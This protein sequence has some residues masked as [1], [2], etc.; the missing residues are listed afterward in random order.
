M[1]Y[2][3]IKGNQRADVTRALGDFK[4]AVKKAGIMSDL[5]DREGFR[6]KADKQRIKRQRA[7]IQRRKDLK[8]LEKKRN[9]L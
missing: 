5:R 3:N 9:T 2:V 1:T 8:Q 4:K 7:G 6:T